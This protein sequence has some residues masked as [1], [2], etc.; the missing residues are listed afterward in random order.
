MN[1]QI[2]TQTELKEILN[3]NPDT[4][5]FTW[6]VKPSS[7]VNV[8]D[9]AGYTNEK[10]YIRIRVNKKRYMAHRLAWLFMTG[11]WPK[12]EI[13]HIDHIRGNNK[14]G[15][16]REAT[17]QENGKNQKLHKSNK[18]GVCGV[19]WNKHNKSWDAQIMVRGK[20][21]PLGQFKDKFEAVCARKSAE[22]KNNFHKNHG[23]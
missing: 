2:I 9:I 19:H 18:S 7:K 3:Y 22:R 21:M 16:L 15:N 23:F 20:Q 1:S 4:G 12:K 14:W 10:G 6:L 11:Y 8:G 13:D 17:H 5:V